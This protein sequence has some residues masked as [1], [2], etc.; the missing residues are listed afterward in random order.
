[1]KKLLPILLLL[2]SSLSFAG[3]GCVVI[4]DSLAQK[5]GKQTTCRVYAYPE[6]PGVVIARLTPIGITTDKAVI[7]MGNDEPYTTPTATVVRVRNKIL[8]GTALW[9][10]PLENENLRNFIKFSAQSREEPYLDLRKY[11]TGGQ[12]AIGDVVAK[13]NNW[14][15]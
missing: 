12:L 9:V 3:D 11:Q 8:K 15:H 4:G 1:M 5:I 7:I 6:Q 10:M 14:V 2:F 13:I